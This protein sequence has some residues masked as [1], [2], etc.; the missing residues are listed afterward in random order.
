MI[1]V[2]DNIRGWAAERGIIANGTL[3]GQ[4]LKLVEEF[5]ELAAGMAKGDCEAIKDA[6][7]DCLVVLTIMEA[8][9]SQPVHS[10][11]DNEG[12]PLGDPLARAAA[13]MAE[14]VDCASNDLPPEFCFDQAAAMQDAL[15]QIAEKYDFTA[16]QCAF[17]AWGQIKDRK[18]YMN[19]QG[20]FV[21][22]AA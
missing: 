20:V 17:H 3:R 19:A 2:Y 9:E 18:G 1:N 11:P 22:E 12:H 16:M 6:I 5:G 14:I 7:G 21:K 15:C 4:S 10:D 13:C 8:L